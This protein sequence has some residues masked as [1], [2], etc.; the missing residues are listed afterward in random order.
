MSEHLLSKAKNRKVAAILALVGTVTPISGLNFSFSG[1]HKLYLGQPR[2]GILYLL[3]SFTLIPR[4]ASAIEA[5]WYLLQDQE[6]FA[7]RFSPDASLPGTASTNPN[8][9]QVETTAQAIRQLDQLRQEG[10]LSE[11]EFE[12]KRRQLLEM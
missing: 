10:L 11:Y 1:L 4:I 12:Q 8:P 2:W 7:Q 9:T 5:I 3:L 6:E